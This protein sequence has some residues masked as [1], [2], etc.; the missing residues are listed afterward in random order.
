[1]VMRQF[2]KSAVF[3]RSPLAFGGCFHDPSRLEGDFQRRYVEPLLV[4][5]E[6]LEGTFEFLRQMKFVRLDQFTDL[7]AQLT[8]P[9]LFIWGADDPTFPESRARA[10]LA[11]FPNVV[12]FHA[13]A[14]AKLFFYEEHPQEVAG[15]IGGFLEQTAATQPTAL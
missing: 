9:T 2:L 10:M 13:V 1:V 6:R 7:H 4:S 14:D 11:Q 15:F 5:D 8:M 12:G 3:R